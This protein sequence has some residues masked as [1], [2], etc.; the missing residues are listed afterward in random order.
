MSI[1]PHPRQGEK[2]REVLNRYRR[3][4]ALELQGPGAARS[5]RACPSQAF[6]CLKQDGQDLSGWTG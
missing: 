1:E 3:A 5:A 4:A 6:I 2:V